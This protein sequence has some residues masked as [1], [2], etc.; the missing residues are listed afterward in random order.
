M[1]LK[2]LTE[3]FIQKLAIRWCAYCQKFEEIVAQKT[4]PRFANQPRNV[5]IELPRRIVNPERI[6]MGDDVNLGPNALLI[7][8]TGYPGPTMQHSDRRERK[9]TF[10]SS[11]SIGS[12]VT[13]TGQLQVAAMSRITI[14]D[15]V[16]FATNVNITDGFHG[17]THIKEAYKYQ[18]LFRIQPITIRQGCWIG[19]NVVICPGVTIGSMTIVGANSVVTKSLPDRCIAV[20]SP[21]RVLK[22]WDDQQEAWVSAERQT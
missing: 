19:Q 3:Q 4:L 8:V 14:E 20:G 16:M 9:Q 2:C 21:A 18:E 12:R 11:I 7:A 1:S 13:S 6:V 22:I 15:D 5:S 17:F 10:D